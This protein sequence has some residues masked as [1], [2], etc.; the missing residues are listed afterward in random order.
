MGK[1][2]IVAEKPS[3]GRDIAKVLGCRGRGDGC[4]F[5][6]DYIVTWAVGHLVTLAAPEE[7]DEIYKEW[8]FDTLPI[9]PNEMK[10]KVLPKVHK[11]FNTVRY[12][13]GSPEIDSIICATDSGRE[14]ELIFRRIY[15]TV[16]CSKPFQRLWI[17]SM[18]DEAIREGFVNLKPGKDYDNLY[19]SARC[20][21]DADWLVGMNGSRAFTLTY[22]SL[23]SVGRVQSPTLALIV[24]RE[25]ERRSFVPEEYVEFWGSFTGYKG[26][27]FDETKEEQA[28]WID[29]KDQAKF[30]EIAA[31]LK[32]KTAEVEH[33]ESEEKTQAPPLL[34]DLTSLQRDANRYF[35]WSAAKT[36]RLAQM[37]YEKRKVITY[38]RT[39][40]RYLSHDL[41]KTLKGRM[42]KLRQPQWE[43]FLPLVEASQRNLYGRFIN[44]ARVSDHH[45]IIPTGKSLEQKGV[46]EEETQLFDLVVRRYISMFLADQ[47]AE[48]MRVVTRAEGMAFESKGKLIHQ[49]GWSELY[50]N[51]AKPKRGA[52]ND[53]EESLPPLQVGDKRRVSSAKVMAKKTQPPAPYTEGTL[54]G[55]MEHAGRLI[56]NDELRE[57]MKDNGLGTPATRAAIIERLIQV[58]YVQRRG[59]I[60]VPTEKGLLLVQVLP[61]PMTSPETTGRW[62]KG[63]AEMGRGEKNA[64]EFMREIREF[65]VE[66]VRWSREKN[67]DVQ[68]P[69]S[70]QIQGTPSAA[71]EPL[72]ACPVCGDGLVMENSKAY[73]CNQWKQGCRFTI[74]K[75]TLQNDGGPMLTPELIKTLVATKKLELDEGVMEL[76]KGKPYFQWQGVNSSPAEESVSVEET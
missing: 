5:G 45:A 59:K 13:M 29:P 61:E 32:G 53:E 16:G 30:A 46:T 75:N 31:N 73:Y 58:R 74:W 47:I 40:S 8:S 42:Q 44:D 52:K 76:K 43:P 7:L 48:Y 67:N 64:E 60:L 49:A 19:D 23:L 1:I 9:L 56:E 37:L 18:T 36:L 21:A 11:Q 63:L 27:Y 10:L 54:L 25:K 4:I 14:G 15:E 22:N 33:V 35:G 62:E 66:V 17:S 55:A 70:A 72:G 2:L 26:R 68:F 38:P 51:F 69:V 41:H 12:W 28:W 20:R 24:A 39:D 57:Q 6:D 50:V 3:V 71:K 65:T 34:Y